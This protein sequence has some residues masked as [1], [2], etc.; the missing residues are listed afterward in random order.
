MTTAIAD[1]IDA[2]V[3]EIES[4]VTDMKSRGISQIIV[5]T[6]SPEIEPFI[7]GTAG[8]LG[9]VHSDIRHPDVTFSA[10]L[11]GT[12][13]VDS[14]INWY[15]LGS[16]FQTPGI[17][18]PGV[19]LPPTT[20][21]GATFILATDGSVALSD[22]TDTYVDAAAAA[23]YTTVLVDLGWNGTTSHFDNMAALDTA[24][25]SASPGSRVGLSVSAQDGF[26]RWDALTR[27]GIDSPSVFD[28]S[29]ANVG[30]FGIN[31]IPV[32]LGDPLLAAAIPVDLNYGVESVSEL[33]ADPAGVNPLLVALGYPAD[34]SGALAYDGA[35]YGGS[36]IASAQAFAWFATCGQQNL[37]A[38]YKVDADGR[39]VDYYVRDRFQ[40][41]GTTF[42]D[43][44]RSNLRTNPR[45]IALP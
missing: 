36:G 28:S 38:R 7:E 1:G 44:E 33:V 30:Y 16:D 9:G 45:W 43:L 4:V 24:L 19:L 32:D 40:P 31:Y 17:V 13:A 29:N 42:F 27:Q 22:A 15:R 23:G 18:N 34:Q 26:V 10:V 37:D 5:D 11:Q 35:T 3:A 14:A 2:V 12:S 41:A 39:K 21:P 8:G 25:S 20:S 6:T